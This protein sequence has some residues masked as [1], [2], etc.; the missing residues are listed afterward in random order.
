MKTLAFQ[1]V[2]LCGLVACGSDD[3]KIMVVTPDAMKVCDPLLQTDCPAGKKCTWLV[4]A[5]MPN[6]VGHIGCAP[7]GTVQL[8]GECT[9]GAPGETGYD[10]CAGG[11]VCSGFKATTGKGICKQICDQ[12]GGM[13]DCGTEGVC[14]VYADLFDLGE[15]TPAAAGVCNVGCNPFADND[16][17]GMGSDF[18]P[19]TGTKCSVA[20]EGCYGAPS[21]GKAPVT[22]FSCTRDLHYGSA[23]FYGHR[24]QCI[25]G[26]G[27]ADP[28]TMKHY[29]NSC[30][31]GYIPFLYETTGSTT[32]VCIAFCEPQNCFSGNCGSGNE[33]RWGKAPNRCTPADRIGTFDGVGGS[34]DNG[35]H[36]QF[37]WYWE[38]DN[39][40]RQYL[41][42]QW[43]DTVGICFDHTKYLYDSNGDNMRD[44]PYP[45]CYQL[46]DGAG[47]GSDPSMP[48][49]FFGA[50]NL[51]CVDSS[52]ITMQAQGKELPPDFFEKRMKMDMPRP[53]FDQRVYEDVNP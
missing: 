21:G 42:S 12:Q 38:I 46:A 25:T 10:D 4:D 51:G 30:N 1:L 17:D 29:R 37:L 7:Q 45:P 26:N 19:R 40:T 32:V 5:Q 18:P 11:L 3:K 22:G 39:A 33:A 47:S 20:S 13:P 35:E 6:F 31:Q 34:N 8:G 2:L 43:S 48:L 49:E 53:L 23:T 36:C 50:A 44:A 15:T 27:C 16:Y 9:Y 24:Q 52:R 14:V 28:V 41:K